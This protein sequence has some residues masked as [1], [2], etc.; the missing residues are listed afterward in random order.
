MSAADKAQSW[1]H[2]EETVL[3]PPA[4]QA[5]RE[6]AAGLGL[7]TITPATGALL[8]AL[9]ATGAR[10]VVEVGTGTG[11]SGVWLLEGMPADGVL[12]TIDVDVEHQRAAR[13]AFTEAGVPS[14]RTRTIGGRALDVLP[15]LADGSY[16]LV[17]LDGD[18]SELPDLVAQAHRLLRPGGMLVVPHALWHDRVADPAR[19]DAD[20]V[21]MRELGR[22][23]VQGE[24][25]DS[26]GSASAGD[27][28]QMWAGVLLPAGDGVLLAVRR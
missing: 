9:A 4:A 1:V 3:E 13:A 23:L 17:L 19:R 10:H 24:A 5:A 7:P 26:A 6:R 16:D 25:A 21:V 15:R 12:T 11:V 27:R 8:R 14:G 20:T 2:T 22:S 18:V 28:D